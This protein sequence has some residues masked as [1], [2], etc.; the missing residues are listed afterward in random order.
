MYCNLTITKMN[1]LA[2]NLENLNAHKKKLL[3]DIKTLQPYTYNRNG[4]RIL[5]YAVIKIGLYI[6]KE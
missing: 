1:L 4:Y 5:Y 3:K 6:I 2:M